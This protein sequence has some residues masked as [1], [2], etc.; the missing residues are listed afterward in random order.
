MYVLVMMEDNR[1]ELL[2]LVLLGTLIK[3]EETLDN[4][5]GLKDGQNG[6][7][8]GICSSV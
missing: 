2:W 1:T 8:A 5:W 3:Y 4:S 7:Q 6:G